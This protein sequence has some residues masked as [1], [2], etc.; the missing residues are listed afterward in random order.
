MKHWLA[1]ALLRDDRRQQFISSQGTQNNAGAAFTISFAVHFFGVFILMIQVT[2][3][4][5]NHTL[6]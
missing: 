5:G 1:L 4:I 3:V 6:S 2:Q